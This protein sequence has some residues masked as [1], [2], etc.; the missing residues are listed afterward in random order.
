[1]SS[2]S[3]QRRQRADWREQQA[4]KEHRLREG[5]ERCRG[6]IGDRPDE[7]DATE[8]PGDERRTGE[9]RDGRDKQSGKNRPPPA[10]DAVRHRTPKEGP[11]ARKGRH[12]A[13]TEL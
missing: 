4:K 6:E 2:V 3:N 10:L 1:M 12:A 11:A 9:R 5:H 13:A 8:G 7:A